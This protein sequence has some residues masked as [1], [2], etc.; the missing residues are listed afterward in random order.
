MSVADAAPLP[1]TA[2]LLGLI[3]GSSFAA[4]LNLYATVLIAG[5]VQLAGWTVLPGGLA[6]LAHPAV[7]GVAGVMF[8]VEF[9]ADKIPFV[10]NVWDAV[11][12]FIRPTAA[13]AI[14]VGALGGAPDAWKVGAALL[15]GTVALTSHGAKASTR[16]AANVSPEPV[17]N[18][19]LSTAEDLLA[20][21]LTWLATMHPYWA[22]AVVAV[23]LVLALLLV[24]AIVRLART[25]LFDPFVESE[26]ESPAAPS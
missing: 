6:V 24:R 19:L 4:G 9:L 21:A 18:W 13:A 10:D 23:L 17:S 20:G 1:G 5:L 16:A 22:S 25:W 11:H 14:A 8:L 26:F 3:L 2:E 12:T 7:L 15:A